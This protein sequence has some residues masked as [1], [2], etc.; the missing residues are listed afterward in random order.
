MADGI[1]W[2]RPVVSVE[3]RRPSNTGPAQRRPNWVHSEV[4]PDAIARGDARRGVGKNRSINL[5]EA[6]GNHNRTRHRRVTL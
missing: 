1:A 2:Q 4:E 5:R 3:L 6:E